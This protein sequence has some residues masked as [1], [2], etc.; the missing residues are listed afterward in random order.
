MAITAAD[1]KQLREKTGAGMMDCK[2][3]LTEADGDFAKA[4]KILKE[5]GLA[6]AAK[7]DGRAT[8]EGRIFSHVG[9]T[10]AGLLEVAS[11]TDFVARNETFIA[12]GNDLVK[13]MTESNLTVDSAEVKETTVQAVSTIKENITA[14]RFVRMEASSNDI[15]ADYIH[16]DGNI[17]VLI[18]LTADSPTA[19]DNE[20]VNE[21]CFNLALHAAAYRPLYLSEDQV[22]GSYIEEQKSIFLKQ[23]ENLGKPEKVMQGI[24]AGKMKKHLAEI[25]FVN[26]GFVKEDKKA[27]SEIIAETG[28]KAGV[29]LTLSDYIVYTVG[30]E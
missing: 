21:L 17:G 16:G 29:K 15:I 25:C 4:E 26:Q 8:N 19:K 2:K 30:Q 23:A 9:N 1:V 28:N 3:A 11:E 27:V 18:K 7:R 5:M 13:T 6:A 22:E 10:A 12:M 24:V 14:R 20:A